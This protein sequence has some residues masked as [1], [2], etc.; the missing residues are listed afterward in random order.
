MA[1]ETGITR[2]A[3]NGS[4]HDALTVQL[5]ELRGDVSELA[6]TLASA[7]GNGGASFAHDVSGSVEEAARS[8]R[9]NGRAADAQIESAI[10]ANPYLALAV[11]IGAGILLGAIS[12]RVY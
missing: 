4:D 11:A 7:I 3:T 6:R 1:L 8:M 10:A 5:A 9:R 12:R 2:A